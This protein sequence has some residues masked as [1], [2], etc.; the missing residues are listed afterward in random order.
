MIEFEKIGLKEWHLSYKEELLKLHLTP[1]SVTNKFFILTDFVKNVS[2]HC[3]I[4]F[5]I[6][7]ISLLK[8]CENETIKSIVIIDNIPVLKHFVNDY[9]N[10]TNINFSEFVNETKAKK[11]SIL[12]T[13]EEIEKINKLSCYLKI[14]AFISNN[15]NLRLGQ[16]VHSI[17]YNKLAEEIVNSEIIFKIFNIIRTKVYR[18]NLSDKYMWEYIKTVQCKDVGVH[19]IEIFNFIMNHILILCLE[20]KNPITY[21][22]SVIN[23]SVKWFLRSVYKGSI[24][25][26]DS[27]STEDI[28]GINID[29]LNTY[30]YNDTLGRLKSIAYEKIYEIIEKNKVIK[31]N[32]EENDLTSDDIIYNFHT[33]I[34]EIEFISPLCESLVFPILSRISEIPYHHFKTLNPEHSAI[35]SIYVQNLLQKTFV[36]EYKNLFNLLGFYPTKKPSIAT[37]YEI[38][39]IIKFVNFQNELK[40]FY[41]FNTQIYLHKIL[42]YFV[43]R[44]ARINFQHIITGDKLGGIPLSKVELDMIYFYS[45][46]FAEKFE[47]QIGKMVKLINQDF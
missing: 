28:Q 10:S 33:R 31:I 32:S 5:D 14:Y 47:D 24:V 46:Y 13:A 39:S 30:S 11:N 8:T 27:I 44:I 37:T 1:N 4:D 7:F 16:K 40:N 25:Y 19:I 36:G 15:V 38:K 6:W 17:I 34:S 41:N 45:N 22:V 21:F 26:S 23:E 9:L 3:G 29:N 43:G 20:D 2:E 42:C 18:Y 12:F 35:L